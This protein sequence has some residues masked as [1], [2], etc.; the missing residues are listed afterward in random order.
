MIKNCSTCL[1]WEPGPNE[2]AGS[3]C[4]EA[5]EQH[6][7]VT[8]ATDGVGCSMWAAGAVVK[9]EETGTACVVCGFETAARMCKIVCDNCGARIDC[10]DPG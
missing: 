8:K 7:V 6:Y 5:C 2:P 1:Y 9:P 4:C 3:G 10:S